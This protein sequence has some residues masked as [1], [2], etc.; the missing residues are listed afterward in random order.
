MRALVLR[1]EVT[2]AWGGGLL[3][4]SKG[5]GRGGG[6]PLTL[7]FPEAIPT[8]P[9]AAAV[10]ASAAGL[11]AGL[12]GAAPASPA[13]RRRPRGRRRRRRPPPANALPR[14]ITLPN[15]HPP[16]IYNKWVPVR[17]PFERPPAFECRFG[18]SILDP[19]P[20]VVAMDVMRVVPNA[21]RHPVIAPN[22]LTHGRLA[23][24]LTQCPPGVFY[25]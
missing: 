10:P 18:T 2:L 5:A 1:G 22:S 6:H 9:P 20:G 19:Q 4:M 3:V 11:G 8:G 16:R 14:S 21:P 24:F 23:G 17:A 12:P 25:F 15:G 13:G 7:H